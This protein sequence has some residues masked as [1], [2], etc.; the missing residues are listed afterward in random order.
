MDILR[1]NKDY[2]YLKQAIYNDIYFNISLNESVQDIDSKIN[3]SISKY[4]ELLRESDSNYESFIIVEMARRIRVKDPSISVEDAILISE[5]FFDSMVKKFGQV[6]DKIGKTFTPNSNIDWEA[7][8]KTVGLDDEYEKITKQTSDKI[9]SKLLNQIEAQSKDIDAGLGNQ[10][11]YAFPLTNSKEA[12]FQG[13]VDI[14]AFYDSLAQDVKENPSKASMYNEIVEDL[15][16]AISKYIND[17][18]TKDG[19]VYAYFG[20]GDASAYAN[21]N[22][23]V[24]KTNSGETVDSASGRGAQAYGAAQ[25]EDH[26]DVEFLSI[27]KPLV[28]ALAGV[29]ATYLGTKLASEV[30]DSMATRVISDKGIL[31]QVKS[32]DEFKSDRPA[33]KK[34]GQSVLKV[35]DDSMSSISVQDGE[36]LVSVMDRAAGGGSG[37]LDNP[38]VGELQG[39]FSSYGGGDVNSGIARF[40]KNFRNPSEAASIFNRI[41]SA[42]LSPDDSVWSNVFTGPNGLGDAGELILQPGDVIPGS[43]RVKLVKA[44]ARNVVKMAGKGTLKKA[45]VG[46]VASK[47][48]AAASSVSASA[49]A[50]PLLAFLG[51]G[52]VASG[53]AVAG[54]RQYAK[55]NSRLATLNQL[56]KLIKPFP[57]NGQ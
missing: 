40:S 49:I 6:A 22:E 15:N 52:A 46:A 4:S 3:E 41:N 10:P 13:V 17:V 54:V 37:L 30:A 11:K 14:A 16:A 1:K 12:F 31:N 26:Q 47:S 45:A 42:G 25:G 34:F 29:L 35:V 55:S 9:S 27:K 43:S 44:I 33:L 20:G 5:G 32:A 28:T 50:G 21:Q 2:E 39:F 56:S 53:L 51:V 24:E 23:Q 36:S 38:T 18:K 8:A 7:Q 48:G 57:E 19:G